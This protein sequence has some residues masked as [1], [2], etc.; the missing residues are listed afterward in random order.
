MIKMARNK[1]SNAG[2]RKK[3]LLH[4]RSAHA[5]NQAAGTML[6]FTGKI[7][8][9]K[10]LTKTMV[11]GTKSALQQQKDRLLEMKGINLEVWQGRK[12]NSSSVRNP[13]AKEDL[14]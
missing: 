3:L 7:K 9:I 12:A 14:E 1:N 5:S 8:S 13:V 4:A 11:S 10:L 2:G 6:G